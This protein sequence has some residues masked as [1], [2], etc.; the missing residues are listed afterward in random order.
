MGESRA[1][2]GAAAD[3]TNRVNHDEPCAPAVLV[4][5]MTSNCV[6]LGCIGKKG[7]TYAASFRGVT[8]VW[9]VS[10][11]WTAVDR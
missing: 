8:N 10:R 7:A 9:D 4:W 5:R 1:P 6:S 11:S 2:P 3:L